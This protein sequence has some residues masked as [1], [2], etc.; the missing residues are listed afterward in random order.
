M[1]LKIAIDVNRYVDF[2]RGVDEAV[3]C[4]RRAGKIFVP[5]IVL[6][7]LRAGF[8]TGRRAKP[9]RPFSPSSSSPTA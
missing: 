5:V 3:A 2:V 9:T 1:A 8:R 4:I 6:A 7:E